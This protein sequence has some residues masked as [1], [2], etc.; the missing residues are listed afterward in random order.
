MKQKA[1][2]KDFITSV[3]EENQDFVKELHEKLMEM[4]CKIDIKS[5]RSGYVVSY[6]YDKKT[7][8]NYVFRKKGM[9]ARI[10]GAH[11]HQ[12]TA[13]LDTLLDEMVLAVLAAPPCKRMIDP[14]SCNPKCSMG[15]DFWLKGEH[16]K[17]CRSSAFMFLVC[18]QNNP[19][20]QSLLLSEVEVRRNI[21]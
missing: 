3:S 15:Y 17:K 13:V 18:P 2:F 16:C 20:I 10:Y 19:Y 9:L 21:Y 12:Y 6:S 8:L 4:G 14:D 5:A 7:V 11:A 1:E